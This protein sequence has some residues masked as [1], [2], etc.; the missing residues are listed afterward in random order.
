M[1]DQ[2]T[3]SR[4]LKSPGM[5]VECYWPVQVFNEIKT[6]MSLQRGDLGLPIEASITL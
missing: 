3:P 6:Q 1:E 5:H 4:P 2:V